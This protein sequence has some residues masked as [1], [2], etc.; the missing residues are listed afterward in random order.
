MTRLSSAIARDPR[1]ADQ[2][3]TDWK[4]PEFIKITDHEDY[5]Y[6]TDAEGSIWFC[7]A[8]RN[9]WGAEVCGARISIE[10]D[11]IQLALRG[12]LAGLEPPEPKPGDVEAAFAIDWEKQHGPL[13]EAF[14]NTETL[15]K[16]PFRPRNLVIVDHL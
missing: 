7:F 4:L 12:N 14:Q 11:T 5:G 3:R 8:Q 6:H 13:P 9:P 2:V 10:G 16:L 15:V 1:N